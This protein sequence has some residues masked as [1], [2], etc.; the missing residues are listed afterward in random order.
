MDFRPVI[1]VLVL[2]LCVQLDSYSAV[3]IEITPQKAAAK[4][5]KEVTV[6]CTMNETDAQATEMLAMKIARKGGRALVIM[7]SDS[8]ITYVE[9]TE[10]EVTVTGKIGT[11]ASIKDSFLQ[12]VIKDPDSEDTGLYICNFRYNETAGATKMVKGSMILTVK[13][14]D[15]NDMD[16]Q[17]KQLLEQV[18]EEEKQ[19][20]NMEEKEKKTKKLVP[21]LEKKAEDTDK[22]IKK[23]ADKEEKVNTKMADIEDKAMKQLKKIEEL[24]KKEETEVKSLKSAVDGILN[25]R[26]K[27]KDD[28]KEIDGKKT[29][30]KVKTLEGDVEKKT[31]EIADLEEKENKLR[32]K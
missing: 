2:F 11:G 29:E 23:L 19:I 6:R 7:D 8:T 13:A 14:S 1:S 5:D 28:M 27:K 10:E 9:A 3:K 17:V 31:K 25:K 21:D 15:V 30:T 20:K 24:S 22:N 32:R 16:D 12:M 18:K 26:K 4:K